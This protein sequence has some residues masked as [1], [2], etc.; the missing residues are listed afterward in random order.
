MLAL[1]IKPNLMP[2]FRNRNF[3]KN[4]AKEKPLLKKPSTKSFNRGKSLASIS[5]RHIAEMPKRFPKINESAL[6]L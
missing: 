5:N 2:E 3:S 1:Q 6:G 4:Q